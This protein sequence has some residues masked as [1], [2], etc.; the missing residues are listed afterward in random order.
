[1]LRRAGK[2][3]QKIHIT[4]KTHTKKNKYIHIQKKDLSD[5]D[6]RDGVIT[7]LEPDI[8]ECKIKWA[9]G[10]ITKNKASGVKEFQLSYF[11]S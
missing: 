7:H 11:K 9:L 1:M 10:G 2:N 8:L 4:I 5:L 6:N 3:T